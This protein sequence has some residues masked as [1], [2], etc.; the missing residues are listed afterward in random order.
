MY[1]KSYLLSKQDILEHTFLFLLDHSNMYMWNIDTSF[2]INNFLLVQ[3]PRDCHLLML[4]LATDLMWMI[5]SNFQNYIDNGYIDIS[6]FGTSVVLIMNSSNNTKKLEL[7]SFHVIYF[8]LII[9]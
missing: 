3:K 9:Y 8:S 7:I 2:V 4:F 5:E 6:C 1:H